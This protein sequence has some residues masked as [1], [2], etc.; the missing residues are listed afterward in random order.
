LLAVGC[1]GVAG[2][3]EVVRALHPNHFEANQC[4]RNDHSVDSVYTDGL[5]PI[6]P[7]KRIALLVNEATI[8]SK[9]R[10]TTARFDT[11]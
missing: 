5:D 4:V 3:E 9:I 2:N 7:M 1:Q 6:Q 10:D 11:S 8:C